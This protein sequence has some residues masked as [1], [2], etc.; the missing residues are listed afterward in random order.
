[1][2]L[3][4]CLSLGRTLS[5]GLASV[6]WSIANGFLAICFLP[7]LLCWSSMHVWQL[8]VLMGLRGFALCRLEMEN[9][10]QWRL[11]SFPALTCSERLKFR[12]IK[13]LNSA[14]GC[15]NN[16]KILKWFKIF[17]LLLYNWSLLWAP[18][19]VYFSKML[20]H[21]ELSQLDPL[22]VNCQQSLVALSRDFWSKR[23]FCWLL[24]PS[25]RPLGCFECFVDSK[26]TIVSFMGHY[27]PLSYLNCRLLFQTALFQP[28]LLQP[29]PGDTRWR[30]ALQ[31]FSL[32]T[33]EKGISPVT[34][35]KDLWLAFMW[36]L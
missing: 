34:Q 7:G 31:L 15:F 12:G 13:W 22:I 21:W 2:G 26:E 18:F 24:V 10:P 19:N 30:L 8:S 9:M 23:P 20:N 35:Q 25:P 27:K 16:T 3:A 33:N 29:S 17:K 5:W 6:V 36:G 1:M 28:Q 11:V 32:G 4:F 14:W